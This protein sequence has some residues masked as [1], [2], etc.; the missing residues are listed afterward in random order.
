[1]TCQPDKI[2]FTCQNWITRLLYILQNNILINIIYLVNKKQGNHAWFVGMKSSGLCYLH[3]GLDSSVLASGWSIIYVVQNG[4]DSDN[5]S[6]I[7]SRIY[8]NTVH[9]ISCC[10]FLWANLQVIH[11]LVFT[12]LISVDK[13][14]WITTSSLH[15]KSCRKNICYLCYYIAFGVDNTA[16]SIRKI[17]LDFKIPPSVLVFILINRNFHQILIHDTG[18]RLFYPEKWLVRSLK[19]DTVASPLPIYANRFNQPSLQ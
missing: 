17:P 7:N 6:L 16:C 5:K 11:C 4:N 19:L 8:Y 15:R 9:I 12:E 18:I 3:S 10:Y 1:M 14:I 2:E 13:F